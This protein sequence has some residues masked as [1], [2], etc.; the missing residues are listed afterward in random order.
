MLLI[1]VEAATS[2]YIMVGIRFYPGLP[3]CSFFPIWIFECLVNYK[4]CPLY[5][6][7][8]LGN[9]VVLLEY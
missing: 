3:R 7:G 4:L 8:N 1:Y 6:V 5:S 2:N 9:S